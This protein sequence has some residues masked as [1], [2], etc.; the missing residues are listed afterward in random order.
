MNFLEIV[1]F[2]KEIQTRMPITN[3][4]TVKPDILNLLNYLIRYSKEEDETDLGEIKGLHMKFLTELY[5]KVNGTN[6][7][8]INLRNEHNCLYSERTANI[9][10]WTFKRKEFINYSKKQEKLD[11]KE[12]YY[13]TTIQKLELEINHLKEK[14]EQLKL[15]KNNII[16]IKTLENDKLKQDI[17]KIKNE[18]EELIEKLSDREKILINLNKK[19]ENLDEL[20]KSSITKNTELQKTSS[21]EQTIINDIGEDPI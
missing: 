3:T 11:D 17:E 10:T 20:Y 8:H 16:S 6:K 15:E 12:I 14:L 1:D 18:K 2:S 5:N 13:M 4:H 9:T 21:S 7:K 19:I